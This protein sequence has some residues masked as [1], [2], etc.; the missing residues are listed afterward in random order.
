MK[1]P[2]VY[3]T[4]NITGSINILNHMVQMNI[5]SFIFSSSAAVYGK[6]KYLPIDESH[7]VIPSNY[8]GYTKLVIENLSKWYSELKGIRFAALRYFNT[9]GYDGKGRINGREKNPA[10]LLPG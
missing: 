2:E 3:S 9:V 8:Y 6:L 4:T 1:I 5:P 7:P 10:N